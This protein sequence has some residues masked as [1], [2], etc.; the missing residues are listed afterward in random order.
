MTPPVRFLFRVAAGPRIGFGH[1]MR[2]RALARA[3]HVPPLV[4]L[5]GGAV[6]RRTARALGFQL[7]EDLALSTIDVVIVDDPS[8]RHARAW[9]MRAKRAGAAT[10]TIND[11]GVGDRVADL[12]IDGRVSARALGGGVAGLRGPRFAVLDPRLLVARAERRQRRTPK[13]QRVLIALGGG[14][15]VFSVVQPLVRE[16]ACRCPRVAIAVA[17]GFSLRSRPALESAR[18]IERPDGLASDLVRSD[19]AVV[20]GGVTL[21]EACAVGVPV[22]A[23]SVVPAQR[24]AI[25]AFAAC[26]AA[27]DARA[28][29]LH[30]RM[31]VTRAGAAVARLLGSRSACRRSA[32]AALRLVDGRG[33]LRI[34]CRLRAL[35]SRTRR[36]RASDARKSILF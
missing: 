12:V 18:W 28:G 30:Q 1:L 31:L 26:G 17:G 33:A 34:A 35:A 25:E 13:R 36:A 10:A 9:L 8:T 5:R 23:L 29:V 11:V 15:H 3:L 6:V 19:V 2:C 32:A 14:S 21:Y 22:V 24:P 4:S 20:S 16:I 27:I 7:A